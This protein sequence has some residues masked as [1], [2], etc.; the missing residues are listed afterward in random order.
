MACAVVAKHRE[1]AKPAAISFC[2]KTGSY[3]D[4]KKVRAELIRLKCGKAQAYYLN[5]SAVLVPD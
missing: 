3:H 4:S 1:A 5:K 2:I